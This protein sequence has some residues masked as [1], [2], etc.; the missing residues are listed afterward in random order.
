MKPENAE[1]DGSGQLRYALRA[2]LRATPLRS[3]ENE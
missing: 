2:P 3:T 1:Q